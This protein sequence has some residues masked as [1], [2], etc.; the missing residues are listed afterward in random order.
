MP[1][2]YTVRGF[3]HEKETIRQTDRKSSYNHSCADIYSCS[4][5]MPKS[6]LSESLQSLSLDVLPQKLDFFDHCPIWRSCRIT[7][8]DQRPIYPDFLHFTS[9]MCSCV[10]GSMVFSSNQQFGSGRIPFSWRLRSVDAY[11]IRRACAGV[12]RCIPKNLR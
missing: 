7:V 12:S 2:N 9:T 1:I 5:F 8:A 3:L 6:K 4:G 10:C 11:R